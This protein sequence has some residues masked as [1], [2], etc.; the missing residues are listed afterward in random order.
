MMNSLYH[1]GTTA[2]TMS[3]DNNNNPSS[4]GGGGLPLSS[5][6]VNSFVMNSSESTLFAPDTDS[7]SS[8]GIYLGLTDDTVEETDEELS[9][10]E[11]AIIFSFL[12]PEDI[13]QRFRR[14]CTTWRDAAKMTVPSSK[15]VVRSE[16]SYNAM[17]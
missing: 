17:K 15:F 7:N 8:N 1:A 14:V 10:D 3:S 16:R 5:R 11:V 2:I 6:T 12:S 9:T 13:I 4:T